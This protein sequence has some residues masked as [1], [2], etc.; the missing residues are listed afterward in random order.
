ME[1]VTFSFNA[2]PLFAQSLQ[3]IIF[4]FSK[5]RGCCSSAS[6]QLET[7]EHQQ[8]SPQ[9]VT[10]APPGDTSQSCPVM[11]CVGSS[12]TCSSILEQESSSSGLPL[13]LEFM[14]SL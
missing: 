11:C 6:I 8:R 3:L 4:L 12:A 9:G 2:L 14:V 1:D 5:I 10:S 7:A 13:G